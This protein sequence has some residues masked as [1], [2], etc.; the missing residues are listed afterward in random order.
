[1]KHG[2]AAILLALAALGSSPGARAESK[3]LPV[4][5]GQNQY[6]P[7]VTRNAFALNP[8][9]VIT[10]T[11]PVVPPS[12]V[13][14]FITG[15]TTLSGTKKVLLQVTEKGKQPDYP[16]PLVEGDGQGRVEVVSIDPDKGAAVIKIDGN[17]KTLTLEK[18]SP[19]PG[20]APAAAKGPPGAMA[21]NPAGTIPLPGVTTAG[22]AAA[23]AHAGAATGRMG[24]MMGGG[25]ASVPSPAVGATG[26][27]SV[28]VGTM[29]GL[30]ARPVRT[31]STGVYVGGAGNTA[32][33]TTGAGGTTTPAATMSREQAIAHIEE[34][35]KLY[36]EAASLGL[37]PK[38]RIPPLPPTPLTPR[39]SPG[40]APSPVPTPTP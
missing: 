35:R 36:N 31:D 33:T 34:Q 25:A 17:E 39:S 26:P 27:G 1:M 13:D 16:P 6:E 15:I 37:I 5:G 14:V 10:N 18:D 24:V 7:I 19:K 4:L 40:T 32:G 2:T 8:I 28:G 29:A 3:G 23:A 38:N 20:G 12:S 30:P 22:A 9:P 11:G 21:P